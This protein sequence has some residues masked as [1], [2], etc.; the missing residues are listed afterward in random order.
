[1]YGKFHIFMCF[2]KSDF[3]HRSLSRR[4]SLGKSGE[5]KQLKTKEPLKELNAKAAKDTKEINHRAKAPAK[6]K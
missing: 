1:M 6:K 4:D 2:G 5:Q 3:L